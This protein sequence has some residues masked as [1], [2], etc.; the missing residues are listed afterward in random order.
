MN[1]FVFLLCVVLKQAIKRKHSLYLI[2]HIY[3]NY[4]EVQKKLFCI[5]TIFIL[6]IMEL[7]KKKKKM[8]FAFEL[9]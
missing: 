9:F 3:R 1:W 4:Q 8:H 7:K 5:K 6:G 2:L